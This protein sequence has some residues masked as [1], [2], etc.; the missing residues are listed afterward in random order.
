MGECPESRAAPIAHVDVA[1]E[2]ALRCL[3][4][5]VEAHVTPRLRRLAHLWLR[6]CLLA[7]ANPLTPLVCARAI[8]AG[9]AGGVAACDA[10]L[11]PGGG[12][13]PCGD[14]REG[15]LELVEITH[16]VER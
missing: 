13:I 9:P 10:L 7:A 6:R 5:R 15:L 12:P 8:R 3:D 16:D 2:F 4:R 14:V 11:A 1:A